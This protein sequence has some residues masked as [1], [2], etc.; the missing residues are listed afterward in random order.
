MV[1]PIAADAAMPGMDADARTDQPNGHGFTAHALMVCLAVLVGGVGA[2]LAAL[3]ASMARCRLLTV[4]AR[5]T[6]CVQ[7]AVGRAV[8]CAP[9]S[10]LSR[11]CVLRV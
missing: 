6:R 11:L 7:V 10:E 2:G 4:C 8:A 1:E 3:A 5:S 9:V